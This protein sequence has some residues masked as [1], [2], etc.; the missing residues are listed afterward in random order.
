MPEFTYDVGTF[1]G[2]VD[3]VKFTEELKA[4]NFVVYSAGCSDDNETCTVIVDRDDKPAIDAVV[5]AHVGPDSLEAYKCLKFKIIDARTYE[6]IE[7]GFQYASK[8]FS[9]SQH[10]QAKM[11]GVHQVRDDSMLTYPVRW[12]TKDDLDCYEIADSDEMHLFYMTGVGTYKAHVDGGTALKDQV[13]AATSKAEV[14][15]VVDPR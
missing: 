3:I 1:N 13:R 9:L 2:G 6:L 5:S 10:A 4:V 15:A 14:D 7:V 12:N 11:M 8:I